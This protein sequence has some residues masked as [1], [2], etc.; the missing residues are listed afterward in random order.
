[1]P[2]L[3]DQHLVSISS[4]KSMQFLQ[5]FD[6]YGLLLGGKVANP[7]SP[8]ARVAVMNIQLN[9]DM[10]PYVTGALDGSFGRR[11]MGF[12]FIT[13]APSSSRPIQDKNHIPW[14]GNS[15]TTSLKSQSAYIGGV[16]PWYMCKVPTIHIPK[17]SPN[18]A[19]HSLSMLHPSQH[20]NHI[21]SCGNTLTTSLK[22]QSSIYWWC[23]TM[24]YL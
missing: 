22:S 1:M 6:S 9:M 14:G 23:A 8:P 4:W 3:F 20:K 2:P 11:M 17:C 5:L 18:W 7:L 12:I 15:L 13:H 16:P 10:C 21:P 24:V 19:L